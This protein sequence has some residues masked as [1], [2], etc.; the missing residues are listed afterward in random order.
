VPRIEETLMEVLRTLE[1]K[2][3]E[4]RDAK[5]HEYSMRL[6]PYRTEDNRIEGLVMV[7]LDMDPGGALP[8]TG[9]R[10]LSAHYGEHLLMLLDGDDKESGNGEKLRN[11]AA[12][13]IQAQE[14][15]KRRISREL[16]DDLNQKL[17]LLHVNVERMEAKAPPGSAA[18]R[19]Y[20][21]LFREAVSD[22]SDSIRRIAY[23]LHPSMLDDLGL[24]VAAQSF[25]EDYARNERIRVNFQAANV[26]GSLPKDVSLCCFRV[27]Q[28]SLR[29][30]SKHSMSRAAMVTLQGDEL[31]LRLI[32]KD[33]GTGF[34]REDLKNKRGLG[35]IGMEER[36]RLVGGSFLSIRNRAKER[37][38]RLKFPWDRPMLSLLSPVVLTVR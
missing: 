32:V 13:L 38:L 3:Q 21:K 37:A 8:R 31:L 34:R 12:G 27:L 30:I 28:E 33:S 36:V 7:F 24:V 23:H 18:L 25:C 15:E 26:P 5:G 6:R 14:D 16:H 11:L 35:L 17:A 10:E 1:P 4:L 29:N 19:S 2:I 22:L 20:L 9:H